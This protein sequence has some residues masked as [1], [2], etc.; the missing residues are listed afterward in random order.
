MKNKL[1]AIFLVFTV[2]SA[3]LAQKSKDP[4]TRSLL[5]G[6]DLPSGALRNNGV[7]SV[8]AAKSVLE[9]HATSEQVLLTEVEVL[10]FPHPFDDKNAGM[11]NMEEIK[12]SLQRSGYEII[13][14][15]N[16]D[17]YSWLMKGGSNFILYTSS[18]KRESNVYIGVASQ[19]PGFIRQSQQLSQVQS[20]AFSSVNEP[21]K[22]PPD[23]TV[24]DNSA[25]TSP[26]EPSGNIL[27]EL[28]G[29]W[30][31]LAG[32]K[33]NW[34]DASTGYMIVSGVSKG[35]DLELNAD[36]TFVQRTVVTSGRPSYRVFVSTSGTWKQTGDQI[37]LYPGDR[38]YRKWENEIIMI[39]EH[40]VPEVY[41]MFWRR[42]INEVT[43][44]D[45]LYVRYSTH[46][47]EQELCRE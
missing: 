32:A 31:N 35:Y 4:V 42:Q 17:S 30:G 9:M 15:A 5:L 25:N 34:Q 2:A 46:E 43:A 47:K 39:D 8:A 19:L 24:R 38:Y 16:D 13:P 12:R 6:I 45:C 33:V 36:G 7:F 23:P 14:V 11:K 27:P 10:V 41:C 18:A 22:T 40:S 29:K 21:L 44:R 37:W 20:A 28:I 26:S 3:I 1:I